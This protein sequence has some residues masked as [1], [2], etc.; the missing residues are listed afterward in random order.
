MEHHR[1]D[2]YPIPKGVWQKSDCSVRRIYST[3]GGN[4]G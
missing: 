1:L 2:L 4:F 3:F